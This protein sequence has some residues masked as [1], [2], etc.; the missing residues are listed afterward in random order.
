M[1]ELAALFAISP[2]SPEPIYRQLVGQVQRRVASGQWPPGTEMPSVRELALAL[3]LNP[4]TVSKALSLLEAEGVLVRRRGLTMVVAEGAVAQR[5]EEEAAA[6]L[7]PTLQRAA[8]EARQLGL[9]QSRALA[10]L[11][12]VWRDGASEE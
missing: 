10:L 12:E 5:S 9:S 3:A 4:M 11:K 8:A 2:G 6:L 1:N 7:R